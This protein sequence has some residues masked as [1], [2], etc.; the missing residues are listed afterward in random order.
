M[1]YIDN[2][3]TVANHSFSESGRL[4]AGVVKLEPEMLGAAMRPIS[5]C[6][7]GLL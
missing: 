1:T 3:T 6:F 4:A 7:L 2:G 5:V